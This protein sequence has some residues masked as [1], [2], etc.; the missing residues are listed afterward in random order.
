MA[1]YLKDIESND[2]DMT[3]DNIIINKQKK[4]EVSSWADILYCGLLYI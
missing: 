2:R 3:A 1:A 4:T